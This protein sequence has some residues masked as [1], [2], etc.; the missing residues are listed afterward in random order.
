MA[1]SEQILSLIKS[2]IDG[3][4]DRFKTLALQ[5]SVAEAKAGHTVF[6]RAIKDLLT[7]S[8]FQVFRPIFTIR[9]IGPGRYYQNSDNNKYAYIDRTGDLKFEANLEYR[10]PILGDLHGA[11]FLDSGNIWLIRND[12]D[13]IGRAHV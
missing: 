4:N 5:L 13:Q 1:T 6:S 8:N 2:H 11:T 10:F 7:K 9:S 3:D 12:P